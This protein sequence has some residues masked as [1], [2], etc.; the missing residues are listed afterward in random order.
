M[1]LLPS[2]LDDYVH[3]IAVSLGNSV[4]LIRSFLK[5]SLARILDW[6]VAPVLN[7]PVFHI[8]GGR[9]FV[10]PV[11]YACP[12]TIVVRWWSRDLID[13]LTRGQ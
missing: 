11:R 9:D 12:D 4:T 5:W 3:T 6:N 7:C 1:P 2:L 13:A 8:H 10:L